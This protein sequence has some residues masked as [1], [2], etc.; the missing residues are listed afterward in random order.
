MAEGTTERACDRCRERRVKCDKRL[1]ACL[2]CEK[3]GKPCPG[4]DKKRKFVDEG[5]TLRKKYQAT[6]ERPSSSDQNFANPPSTGPASA[7]PSLVTTPQ[8]V[9]SSETAH[10]SQPPGGLL[11]P[12]L[13]QS[14]PAALPSGDAFTQEP[15]LVPPV[16]PMLMNDPI[17]FP[18]PDDAMLDILWKDQTYDP[19]WFDLE[20]EKY[21][22][23]AGN[24]C[25]FIP[26]IPNIVDEV[27]QS[28]YL[29][30]NTA[31]V[32]PLSTALGSTGIFSDSN[33]WN[34]DSQLQTSALITHERDHEMAFLVRHFTECLGPWMDL[35]DK[36]KHFT[37]LVPLKALRDALLRNAIA[38]VAAKQLGRVKGAK[39]FVGLQA[40]RPSAMEVLDDNVEVDWYYK[41][42]NY[43]DKA[44]AFSRQYLQAV[45][46]SLEQ[47]STP[48]TQMALSMANS[49][50]LL[51]AVSLF[52]LYESLDN[53]D[54]GWIQHLVGLKS[55][56]TA[57]TPAQQVQN[58]ITPSLTVGRLASFWNFAR[59]DYQAAYI[60]HQATLLD[61][62][63]VGLWNSCGLEISESGELYKSTDYVRNDPSHSRDLAELVAHTLLWLVLKVMNYLANTDEKPSVR[64]EQWKTLTRQLD[65]WY[66]NLPATYQPCATIRHPRR[67]SSGARSPLTEVFFSID[68][69]AAALQLYHFARI[70]LLLHRPLEDQAGQVSRLKAYR[71][72]STEAIAHAHEIIG[73]ALGRPHPAIRVEMLLPLGIAGACLEADEERTIVLELLEAI[74]KDTGCSTEARRSETQF[75]WGWS[76]E[77]EGIA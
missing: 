50:D 52:S 14:S 30:G 24:T 56:L 62:D 41:A 6:N 73:I 44:I 55:L 10:V 48:N 71:E 68:V 39:P 21:Y 2:R 1:P 53:F 9:P 42:A 5:I 29:M 11:R 61:T 70:Q 60:N 3:L 45:S 8:N 17:L 13:E 75:Q 7:G 59:A 72:V 37:H 65:H 76:R 57:V 49:D 4:Y 19:E 32:T 34:P 43:Y 22:S 47:P 46:G 16:E 33:L 40:Q 51:V 74:E 12:K 20:P 54:A 77:P 26:N 31:S 69:C 64:Q 38:A 66:G 36:D 28:G 63:D 15:P 18:V 23:L 25:G 27:D 35:F 58:Q 67:S